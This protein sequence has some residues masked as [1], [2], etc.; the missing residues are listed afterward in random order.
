MSNGT[1][2]PKGFCWGTATASYQ[3][4]GGTTAD[5]R[6]ESIWDRFSATPGATRNGD[7][8]EPACQSYYRWQD[9]ISL[10]TSLQNN[11]YRF[12]IAWPR[13]IPEGIGAINERGLDYY[14][15]LVD[16]LLDAGITP[17]VTLYHWDL[18]QALENTGGWADAA[19]VSAFERYADAVVR[20]LGD[21]VVHWS[22]IN[23][24]WCVSM[25]G[26][27][28]GYHAPGRK[29]LKTA[30]V[31]AHNLLLAHGRAMSVIRARYTQARAGIVLN[32]E[33]VHA[34]TETEADAR[35]AELHNAAFNRWFLDPV[36][37]NG[38]PRAAWDDY[39]I[40][41]PRVGPDDMETIA[42][43]VDYIA[44]NYYTRRVVHD[45][46]GGEGAVLATRDDD[47]VTAR[48]WEIY[49]HGIVELLTEIHREHPGIGEFFV[50]ENGMA[51]DDVPDGE[52]VNDPERIAYIRGH[53]EA[54][55]ESIDAGVPVRGYFVWSLMDNFEWETGYES[56]FGLAYVDFASQERTL[57]DSG[58]WYARAAEAN[59]FPD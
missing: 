41:A 4:E 57:K 31:A 59:A 13:V 39:G 7:T 58:Y 56:R 34:A 12:S 49:P 16:A 32:M 26:Y 45:P 44:L 5:G 6:G 24:P 37:G 18:P 19:V 55:L 10:M 28:F 21:R 27:R 54:I 15:R 25:L 17:F 38:Y 11:A 23:E 33:A 40:D 14:D 43:P 8:G 53:L 9:D 52:T 2:F 46:D 35:L 29:D 20:R 30:L 47:N 22:T 51:R 1:G 3:I 36:M 42:Q 50:T 48:G